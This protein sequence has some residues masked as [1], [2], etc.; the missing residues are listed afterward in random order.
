MQLTLKPR[1][2]QGVGPTPLLRR[3]KD[4]DVLLG[5]TVVVAACTI[6]AAAALFYVHPPGQRS[7]AFETTDASS[8]D[9]GQDVRIAGISVGKV[10]DIAIGTETVRIEAEIDDATFIGSDTTVDVRMLTPVGGYAVTVTPNGDN[11]L[12]DGVIPVDHVSVPYSISDVLQ[13]APHVTDNVDGTVIDANIDQVADA[14]E[15]NSGSIESVIDGLDSI[16]TVMDRQRDQVRTIV[17]LTSE[18]TQTFNG[19]RDFV[20]ELLRQVEIVLSTYNGV[21]TGFNEAYWL[22]GDVLTRIE[23]LDRFYLNHKDQ[24]RDAVNALR[25]T[26]SEFQSTLGP[27]MDQMQGFKS[28]LEAVLGPDGLKAIAGEALLASNVCVPIPGR[29][30]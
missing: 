6:L 20:F 25:Q 7:L 4:N 16:A 15:H 12:A 26:I 29:T 21:H 9:V 8:L 1:P 14:L 3:I 10:T 28:Q 2:G 30:C 18:Y 27:A 24:V 23:S 19:S 22:L 11:A 17:N 5:T 13:A